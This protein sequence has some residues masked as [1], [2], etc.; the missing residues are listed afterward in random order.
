MRSVMFF[1]MGEKGKLEK[2]DLFLFLFHKQEQIL[3]AAAPVSLNGSF[4]MWCQWRAM[5]D[6]RIHWK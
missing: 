3:A 6:V 2:H 1:Q 5:V 4:Q